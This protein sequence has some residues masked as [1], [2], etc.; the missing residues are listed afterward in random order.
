[1]LSPNPLRI[2]NPISL[3]GQLSWNIRYLN[4]PKVGSFPCQ[5]LPT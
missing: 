4:H 3:S 1:V 5:E 2:N